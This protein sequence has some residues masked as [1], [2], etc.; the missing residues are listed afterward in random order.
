M[1]FLSVVTGALTIGSAL[2]GASSQSKAANAQADAA[3]AQAAAQR[4]SYLETAKQYTLAAEMSDRQVEQ[5]KE[6]A[7]LVR[8]GTRLE[9]RDRLWRGTE[10]LASQRATMVAFG[11]DVGN[12][13]VF[14]TSANAIQRRTRD[15]VTSDLGVIALQGDI[16]VRRELISAQSAGLRSQ[17]YRA[18]ATYATEASDDIEDTSDAIRD[19]GRTSAL[20]TVASGVAKGISLLPF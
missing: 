5:Y 3:A 15:V 11:Y 7:E 18:S 17:Q 14:G 6:N 20:A 16:A 1:S 10:T 2:L 4:K 9:M 8:E 19:A 12:A 13:G